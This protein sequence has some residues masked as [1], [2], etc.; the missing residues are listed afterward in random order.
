MNKNRSN[1]DRLKIIASLI[2]LRQV[3][4]YF[5]KYL[6]LRFKMLELCI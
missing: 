1:F 2:Y 4:C 5:N 6:G 3:C